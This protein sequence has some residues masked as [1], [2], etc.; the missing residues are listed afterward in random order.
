MGHY[1]W[2]ATYNFLSEFLPPP[3][4]VIAKLGRQAFIGFSASVVSGASRRRDIFFVLVPTSDLDLSGADTS[5]NSLR[6]LKTYRQTHEGDIGYVAAAKEIIARDGV[7]GLFGRGLSTRILYVTEIRST[8]TS[9]RC[10]RWTLT[11]LSLGHL[12]R[13]NGLQ[14][15]LF[16]ILWK[17]IADA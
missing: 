10:E 16:S 17:L 4:T 8:L 7:L 1:P 6:V 3:H 14:G 13:T 15:L 2:F 12:H 5:S 9:V 11:K